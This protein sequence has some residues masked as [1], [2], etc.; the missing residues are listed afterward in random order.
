[1]RR[2]S[3]LLHVNGPLSTAVL[4]NRSSVES[5]MLR[6][7]IRFLLRCPLELLMDRP[8]VCARPAPS[9]PPSIFTL[10]RTCPP[11][12]VD[13]RYPNMLICKSPASY[14]PHGRAARI[15][16]ITRR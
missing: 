14:P 6:L 9:K 1:M 4:N 7:P 13:V 3:S 12:L 10:V 5:G 8:G 11:A 16:R 15:L 2:I